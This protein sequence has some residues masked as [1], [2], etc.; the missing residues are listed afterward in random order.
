[1]W[2]GGG[3]TRVY[4]GR[5]FEMGEGVRNSEA[6]TRAIN[7]TFATQLALPSF[8]IRLQHYINSSK[9]VPCEGNSYVGASGATQAS[10][11]LAPAGDDVEVSS[12]C[13]DRLLEFQ[14]KEGSSKEQQER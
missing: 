12:F 2:F 13:L 8:A 14:V 9:N 1:V 4:R 3:H 7:S 6:D 10:S 5:R 11:A